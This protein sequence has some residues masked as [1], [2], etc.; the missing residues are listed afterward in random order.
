MKLRDLT[1][2]QR[3]TKIL[4]AIARRTP[5]VTEVNGHYEINP[6]LEKLT[7]LI[8]FIKIEFGKKGK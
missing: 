4:E 2:I 1:R 3:V 7:K 6:K 5:G 8:K